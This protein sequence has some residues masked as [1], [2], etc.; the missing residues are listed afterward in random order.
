MLRVNLCSFFALQPETPIVKSGL[1]PSLK[2]SKRPPIALDIRRI[3]M[4]E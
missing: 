1:D 3:R 4:D 2:E